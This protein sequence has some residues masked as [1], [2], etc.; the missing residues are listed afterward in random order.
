MKGAVRKPLLPY[1]STQPVLH[2]HLV[3]EKMF[4]LGGYFNVS[5]T[6]NQPSAPLVP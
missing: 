4:L 6:I 1:L 5:G 3:L 2:S